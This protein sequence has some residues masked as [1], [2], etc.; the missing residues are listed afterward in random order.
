MH[1]L[2]TKIMNITLQN[3]FLRFEAWS[4]NFSISASSAG[5]LAVE[6]ISNAFA[7][8][9]IKRKKKRKAESDPYSLS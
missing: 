3:T 1:N 6:L 8:L 9:K 7:Y 5:L 4:S 2:N